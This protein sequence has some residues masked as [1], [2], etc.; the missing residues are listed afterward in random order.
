MSLRSRIVALIGLVLLVSLILGAL[1][2]GL[3]ARRTLRAELNAALT[4]GVHTV[5]SAYED[6]PRSDHP[7]RDLRQLTATFDGDRHLRATLLDGDGRALA[8]SAAARE[9]SAA[10]GWFAALLGPPPAP[11]R[12]AAPATA[13]AAEIEL[14]PTPAPDV[15]ADWREALRAAAILAA[16]AALGM[17][18]AF[19]AMGAGLRPLTRLSAA[20]ARIGEGDYA[21]RVP[22]EGPPE[23]APLQRAFNQMAGQLAAMQSRNRLLETQLATIQDEERAEVARDLHDDMGPQLFSVTIDAQIIA[24]LVE[25]RGAPAVR[26]RLHAIQE[27]V[28]HMQRLVRELLTRLR[29]T[30]VTELGLRPAIDDLIGF[31]STRRA[32]VAVTVALMDE[33]ALPQP[34]K[35]ASFRI[36]QEA[37]SNAMR[38][39]APS[40]VRISVQPRAPGEIEII[41]ADDGAGDA[42]GGTDDAPGGGFGLIGIRE[43]VQALGGALS[44]DRGEAGGGWTV[45]ARLPLLLSDAPAGE[46]D[47]AA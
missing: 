9:P 10:P 30:P 37:L 4:G 13:A 16:A 35:D 25:G 39:A 41:V 46:A 17:A 20:L 8:V 42:G 1:V 5:Q 22:E 15:G 12:L 2:A 26:E 7:A 29:P 23:L 28:S 14:A 44:I 32:E 6:L 43:R 24:G 36:V 31:W 3:E 47:V 19:L 45:S 38:H 33:A 34:V 18:L 40:T 11:V 21:A 27:A